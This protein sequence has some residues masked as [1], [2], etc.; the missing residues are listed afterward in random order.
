[1]FEVLKNITPFPKKKQ[2]QGCV[3]RVFRANSVP[4]LATSFAPQSGLIKYLRSE[5][6]SKNNQTA[7]C[8]GKQQLKIL[9]LMKLFRAKNF[10]F[11]SL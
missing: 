7:L 5:I 9:K 11:S 4:E 3:S 10:I 2:F 8:S 1:M 6:I